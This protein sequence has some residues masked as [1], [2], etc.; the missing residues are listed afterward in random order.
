[1][2]IFQP[3]TYLYIRVCVHICVC[4]YVCIY[5][6]IYIYIYI[7]IYTTVSY[8]YELHVYICCLA[9]MWLINHWKG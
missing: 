2:A 3:K 9:Y 5:V 1:M 8:F 7:Y 4:I 6:Y